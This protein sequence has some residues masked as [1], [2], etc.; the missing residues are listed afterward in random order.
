MKCAGCQHLLEWQSSES[1]STWPNVVRSKRAPKGMMDDDLSFAVVGESRARAEEPRESW[2]YSVNSKPA[3]WELRRRRSRRARLKAVGLAAGAVAI[4]F[5]GLGIAG[6]SFNSEDPG[7]P[8]P[9]A[10]SPGPRGQGAVPGPTPSATADPSERR[11][12]VP[13]TDPPDGVVEGVDFA[14]L[15]DYGDPYRW[16]CDS[17]VSVGLLEDSPPDAEAAVRVALDLLAEKTGLI[18][19][20]APFDQAQI[21]I[22]YRPRGV[23]YDGATLDAPRAGVA[24][25]LA[26]GTELIGVRILISSDPGVAEP[27]SEMGRA[28][29]LHE[30]MHGLGIGHA[31]EGAEEVMAPVARQQDSTILGPGDLFALSQV[32]CVV[33]S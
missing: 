16:P 24:R 4:A 27:D 19:V 17:A 10:A 33:S 18:F 31:S 32:G 23:E 7:S 13:R 2:N 30:L 22:A 9:P 1:L 28:V 11:V 25:N 29:L 26:L 3:Y 5:A 12:P 21:T 6:S 8:P 14:F 15:P 20:R